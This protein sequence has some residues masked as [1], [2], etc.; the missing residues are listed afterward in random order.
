VLKDGKLAWADC[1]CGGKGDLSCLLVLVRRVRNNLFHGGKFPLQ[2]IPEISRDE[3]L[4][5]SSLTVLGAAL[6]LN[7]R[8]SQFFSEEIY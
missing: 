1:G 8:V 4:L 3:S 5:Q 2:P 7:P 6:Q